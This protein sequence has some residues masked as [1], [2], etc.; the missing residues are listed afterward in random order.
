[1]CMRWRNIKKNSTYIEMFEAGDQYDMLDNRL[2]ESHDPFDDI[3][4]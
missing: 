4:D 2:Q 3:N 1:M